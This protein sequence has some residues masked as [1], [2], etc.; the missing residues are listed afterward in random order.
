VGGVVGGGVVDGGDVEVAEAEV[1]VTRLVGVGSP[2]GGSGVGEVV[3]IALFGS[4]EKALLFRGPTN[5][6][7]G[8]GEGVVVAGLLVFGGVG[9]SRQLYWFGPDAFVA[10]GERLVYRGFEFR[11]IDLFLATG[12]PCDEPGQHERQGD[13]FTHPNS[14]QRFGCGKWGL[15]RMSPDEDSK[16]GK[17]SPGC[18]KRKGT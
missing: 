15:K 6:K 13:S 14:P 10:A 9:L 11:L 18:R 1:A 3:F 16:R 5:E 17:I 12:C 4:D 2:G 7:A 8:I